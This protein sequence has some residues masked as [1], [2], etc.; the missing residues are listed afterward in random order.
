MIAKLLEVLDS[1]TLVSPVT[2]LRR[3]LVT[4]NE[5]EVYVVCY[6]HNNHS[7]Y[8]TG[9]YF[10]SEAA[11]KAFFDLHIH[12]A[13]LTKELDPAQA[14][15]YAKFKPLDLHGLTNRLPS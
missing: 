9:Q 6:N 15:E 5:R 8:T 1:V 10:V 11:S 3:E 14:A 2:I 4:V 7:F 13:D 12:V